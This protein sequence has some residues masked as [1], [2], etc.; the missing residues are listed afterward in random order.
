VISGPSGAGKGT[1]IALVLKALPAVTTA[2]SA[3]TREPRPGEREGEHYHFL[4]RAA[5]ADAVRR[6]EFLEWVEYNGNLYGTLRA[7]VQ[8]KLETGLDVILEIELQGARTIRRVLPASVSI[9]LAPPSRTALARRLAGRGT[10]S[11]K[12]RAARLR[13]AEVELAAGSEFDHVVINDTADRAA[14]E[15]VSIIAEQRKGP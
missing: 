5:F 12:A 4:S 7:E 13:I 9:F 1:V 2:V 6:D 3:T 14:A 8:G 10:D 15:V 11:R